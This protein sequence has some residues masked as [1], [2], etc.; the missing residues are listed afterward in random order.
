MFLYPRDSHTIES[1][2]EVQRLF[3]TFANGWPGAGLLVQRTLTSTFLLRIGVPVL[4]ESPFSLSLSPQLLGS[5][6]GILLLA[7]LWTPIA[8]ALIARLE[9]WS[10][11]RGTGD[12]WI[13]LILVTLS[14]TIAV[15]GPASCSLDAY[16]F[17]SKRFAASQRGYGNPLEKKRF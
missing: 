7:D 16:L 12:L 10:V 5:V 2:V 17:G 15:I 4:S 11:I 3:S 9:M 13:S 14:G 1:E 8:G 6:A